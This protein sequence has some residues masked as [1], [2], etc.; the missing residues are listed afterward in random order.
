[1][2][3]SHIP[4][5]LLLA[6]CAHPTTNPPTGMPQQI[7]SER[8]QES[9]IIA[10]QQ[11]ELQR[12][13]LEE[14]IKME[15]RLLAVSGRIAPAAAELCLDLNKNAADN[16]CAYS[17]KLDEPN[18]SMNAHADGKNIVISPAMMRFAKTDEELAFV[19]SH[20]TAHN[21]MTHTGA[22]TQNAMIGAALGAVAD[23][24]AAYN[25]VSTHGDLSE[26]GMETGAQMYSA[27]FEAEADYVGLYILARS[28]YEVKSV[29]DF[30]RRL[31]AHEPKSVYLASDHPSDPERFVAMDQTIREINMKRR[32]HQPLLP[33]MK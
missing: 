30:W 22:Q 20:E 25:H 13:R 1:M 9:A 4:L 14:R 10:Q 3:Y 26:I 31:A 18:S 6:A 33:E 23:S 11:I 27:G 28:G 32:N 8:Q 19:L 15:Q 7:L 29:P 21:I 16:V 2:K 5:L 12:H 24:V 17:Y